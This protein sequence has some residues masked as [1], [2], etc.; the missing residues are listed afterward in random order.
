MKR[1]GTEVMV[2]RQRDESGEFM[3]FMRVYD[4]EVER[5][6]GVASAFD[7]PIPER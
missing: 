5:R 4:E 3:A 2:Q 7:T 1:L 6:G